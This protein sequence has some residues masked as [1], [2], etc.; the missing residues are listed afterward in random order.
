MTY[1]H[2]SRNRDVYQSVTDNIVAAI[3]RGAG[4]WDFPWSR[5]SAMPVNATTGNAYRGVNVVS[6]WAAS[7][8]HSWGGQ[9]A[10]YKQWQSIGAQVKQGSRGSTVVF[11]K[12]LERESGEHDDDGNAKVDR[13]YLARASAVFNADQV[14]GYEPES[15]PERPLFERLENVERFVGNTDA[16]IRHGGERA[17]YCPS[18]DHIQMPPREAFTGTDTSTAQESFYSTALHEL[19]HWSGH[20][21][22]CD[23]DLRGRFGNEAYAAEEMIAELGAAFMCAGL[24]ISQ[25]PRLDHAQ[26]VANWLRILKGDKRAIFTA[27]AKAA[28][29]SDYLHSLQSPTAVAA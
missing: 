2:S 13:F 5:Q 9:W 11:Y 23:R 26:Y 19:T 25:T 3:E 12:T 22:R 4:T 24:G 8:A 6:L 15:V 17:F 16:T 7:G 18:T 27:S 14:D 1:R 29:A 28:Q 10:S 21:K 20:A